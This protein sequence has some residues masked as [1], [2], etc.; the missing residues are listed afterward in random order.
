MSG[1]FSKL[2]D[3]EF[4]TVASIYEFSTLGRNVS[5]EAS[6]ALLGAAADLRLACMHIPVIDGSHAR[7]ANRA[8]RPLRRAAMHL[9]AA[10]RCFSVLPRVFMKTYEAEIAAARGQGKAKGITLK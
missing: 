3:F 9:W 4:N 7:K 8:S 5:A 10:Q 1:D 2:D 6:Q